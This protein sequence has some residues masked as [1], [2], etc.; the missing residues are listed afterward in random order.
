MTL[1]FTRN[2]WFNAVVVVLAGVI[3]FMLLGYRDLLGPDEGRYAE[4][5][6]EMLSTGD[7]LT[8]RLNGFKYFEKPPM[9]YWGSAAS[10]FVFGINNTAAR[11][12]CAGLGF[13]GALWIGYVGMR[14][15]GTRV[16]L[17]S[18]LILLS[19]LLYAIQGHV[20]TLDMGVSV[21]LAIAVGALLL[22]QTQRSAQGRGLKWMLLAWAALAGAVLSKG[23][24]GLVL[25]GG[26]L[27]LY[28]FLQRDWA[29]WK[30][31]QL[32]KGLLLFLLLVAPW[33]ILV[34]LEN[35]E[36]PQFFFIHEHFDRYTSDVHERT[37]PW[38]Y[39]FPV[40]AVGALPWVVS[41]FDTLIRPTF[42]WLPEPG[43]FS[44]SK[45][46]WVYAL[47]IFFFFSISHSKLPAYI[48]PMFPA[49]ALLVAEKLA[50]RRNLLIEAIV[51]SIIVVGILIYAWNIDNF[52]K[53]RTPLD[54]HLQFRSWLV[55]SAALFA[56]AAIAAFIWGNKERGITVFALCTLLALQMIS[57]GFQSYGAVR[58][59]RV[60]AQVVKPYSDQGVEIYSIHRYDQS[61]PFYLQRT[62]K[63][64]AFRGEM[65]F[66]M[67][68]EP[69]IWT[70]S[71]E[72]FLPLWQESE[73]AIAI[74][75]LVIYNDLLKM[76][77]PMRL[78][79]QDPRHIAVARY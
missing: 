53:P 39:F 61:L 36:F 34:S 14:L 20:N 54:L 78:I 43:T 59:C 31:L 5:A 35:P 17:W 3:W 51:A 79:Y 16:G 25:P 42:S 62:I 4:I 74:L 12:W 73:Q 24:I 48:L 72:E 52:A 77:M 58:S 27:V 28:S 37:K 60:L 44:P 38:W 50:E 7:W 57:W 41:V 55:G 66:G 64:V 18:L 19:S 45:F 26:A 9:Q 65:E 15:H 49:L 67:Y 33:F 63:L 68:Q 46:L 22:A 10:M 47:F 75:P 30:N 11:L 2:D 70:S 21:F 71:V 56:L 6:R 40:L 13:I 69:D 8:P 23:L 32:T 29:I 1:S 76:G